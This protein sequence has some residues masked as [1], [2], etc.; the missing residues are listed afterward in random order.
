M[1]ETLLCIFNCG[2]PAPPPSA[3]KSTDIH[4][5]YDKMVQESS[6]HFTLHEVTPRAVTTESIQRQLPPPSAPSP[7]SADQQ[8]GDRDKTVLNQ[9][10]QYIVNENYEILGGNTAPPVKGGHQGNYPSY[11]N[12]TT[13]NIDP[14]SNAKHNQHRTTKLSSNL[15]QTLP[16]SDATNP[17][18]QLNNIDSGH[19]VGNTSGHKHSENTTVQNKQQTLANSSRSRPHPSSSSKAN[20][21]SSPTIN[22]LEFDKLATEHSSKQIPSQQRHQHQ[23]NQVPSAVSNCEQSVSKDILIPSKD[24][25]LP[26]EVVDSVVE[27]AAHWSESTGKADLIVHDTSL[28]KEKSD[29]SNSRKNYREEPT[30]SHHHSSHQSAKVEQASSLHQ[31]SHSHHKHKES[32]HS[33]RQ[34]SAAVGRNF[35]DSFN[36]SLSKT[37]S[38]VTNTNQNTTRS[39]NLS[40]SKYESGVSNIITSDNYNRDHRNHPKTTSTTHAT[41]EHHKRTSK[42]ISS[43]MVPQYNY[44]LSNTSDIPPPLPSCPPPPLDTPPPTK[45]KNLP[46]NENYFSYYPTSKYKSK[47]HNYESY[48]SYLDNRNK[49]NNSVQS[50]NKTTEVSRAVGSQNSNKKVQENNEKCMEPS[51]PIN[52][53]AHTKHPGVASRIKSTADASVVPGISSSIGSKDDDERKKTRISTTAVVSTGST[54]SSTIT[55]LP[56]QTLKKPSADLQS[57]PNKSTGAIPK[58]KRNNE[59]LS[60][61]CTSAPSNK[62]TTNTIKPVTSST[63][64][65]HLDEIVSFPLD[66]T[67]SSPSVGGGAS[68]SLSNRTQLPQPLV[69]D[70]SPPSLPSSSYGGSSNKHSTKN[71]SQRHYVQ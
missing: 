63:N 2:R 48:P 37:T 60:T 27:G 13:N 67:V 1:V 40:D 41:V 30:R 22:A 39:A 50:D 23:R 29:K 55:N 43:A 9:K 10:R 62:P 25:T 53:L 6:T 71:N 52:S 45:S 66:D 49:S 28:N 47:G 61:S 42:K 15:A 3:S 8:R 18:N 36:P 11:N 7:H 16:S 69:T 59:P 56:Q 32:H 20:D 4:Q 19:R 24:T 68:I 54:S 58:K 44:Y 70:H 33:S 65:N 38:S 26:S 51:A 12:N 46:N 5:P 21:I 31:G 34:K 64:Q 17:R 35:H 57:A 14:S